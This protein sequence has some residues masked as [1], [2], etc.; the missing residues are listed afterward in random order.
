MT[1]LHKEHDDLSKEFASFRRDKE[2]QEE[3][4]DK[5]FKQLEDKIRQ[6]QQIDEEKIS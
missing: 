4:R 1:R 6:L 2:E 5:Q 3:A